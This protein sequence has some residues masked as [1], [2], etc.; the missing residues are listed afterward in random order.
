MTDA[1]ERDRSGSIR[2]DAGAGGS[3]ARSIAR[4]LE[5]LPRD[6]APIPDDAT[7]ALCLTHDVDRPYK[8]FRSFYRALQ[9]RPTYHLKTALSPSN[10]YWQFEEIMALEEELGVR[11][12]FYF[13]NEQHL[14]ADR[15][16]GDW[17]AAANW[18]EHLGR[19]DVAAPEMA[20]IVRELDAGGWE[21]GLHG[22]YHTADDRERLREEKAVLEDALG[23]PI[24]GGRQH[25]LRLS[26]PETWHHHRA[27]GLR[28]DSSLG[29]GT[30]CGFTAGYRP[31]R[32]FGDDF[33]VFPVTIMEQALPDPDAR[34]DDARDRCEEV[35]L[36][37]AANDAVMT[38]LWHPRYFNERE[39]PGYR[40]LYRWLVER[41]QE[42]GAWI[43]SPEQLYAKL[44]GAS[45][46]DASTPSRR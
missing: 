26:V 29:S 23:R 40:T 10:P 38:A 21:V 35:L 45:E 31:L 41:A 42:L 46:T 1:A 7:F 2:T 28:Y 30:E 22:S 5:E 34:Y 8:G 17:F 44:E 20:E 6:R 13:L 39:F 36:E 37:A 33:R 43:G 27:I 18:I 9:E 15:P 14:L 12:A 11:S 32:P 4:R 16:V 19:Y 24:A 3:A 25:H